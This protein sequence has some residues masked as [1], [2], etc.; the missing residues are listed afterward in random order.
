MPVN[1][2][3]TIQD[4]KSRMDL[5]ISYTGRDDMFTD[6]IMD[7]TALIRAYTRR[8]YD[9]AAYTQ[10]ASVSRTDVVLS[11]GRQVNKITLDERPI[12]PAKMPIVTYS[13]FGDWANAIPLLTSYY[14]VDYARNQIVLYPGD[15]FFTERSLKIDYYAGYL[16]D[17][18]D[19]DLLLVSRN[20][21]AACA[22]QAAFSIKRQV[23][24]SA[25]EDQARSGR[26]NL[27]KYHVN[28]SGLIPESAALLRG[29]VRLLGMR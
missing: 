27:V 5:S 8:N 13:Q 15:T 21:K 7:A 11:I 2:F 18:T 17:A 19:T 20:I 10:Y 3:C 1:K 24:Q 14:Q 26:N 6:A 4:V 28:A 25:G 12:D 16:P 22:V 29:E 23:N 9:Y